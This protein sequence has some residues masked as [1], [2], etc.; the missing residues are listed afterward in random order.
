MV[1]EI[2]RYREVEKDGNDR[3]L[4]VHRLSPVVGYCYNCVNG[5]LALPIH[6]ACWFAISLS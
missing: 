1:D 2:E 5:A 3:F 4:D 6:A